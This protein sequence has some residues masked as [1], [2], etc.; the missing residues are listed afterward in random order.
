[1]GENVPKGVAVKSSLIKLVDC[2]TLV[3]SLNGPIYTARRQDHGKNDDQIP[4]ERRRSIDFLV[5]A[6]VF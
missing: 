1:M 3:N 6:T 5:S 4:T 2:P